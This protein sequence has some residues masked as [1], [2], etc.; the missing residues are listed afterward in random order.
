M[1]EP[2]GYLSAKLTLGS[3]RVPG[4]VTAVSDKTVCETKTG[5]SGVLVR[6]RLTGFYSLFSCG[7]MHSVNQE[8]AK[9]IEA[10]I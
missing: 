7:V 9:L 5:A 6:N 1:L 2:V 4:N 3:Y 10:E 8:E